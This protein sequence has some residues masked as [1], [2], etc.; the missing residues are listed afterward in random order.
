MVGMVMVGALVIDTVD[1]ELVLFTTS[2]VVIFSEAGII[3]VTEV[4]DTEVMVGKS[5]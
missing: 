1:V 4:A 2:L 5:C 3:G